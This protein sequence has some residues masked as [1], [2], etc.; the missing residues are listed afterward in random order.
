VTWYFHTVFRKEL[1]LSYLA[2]LTEHFRQVGQDIIANDRW[3]LFTSMVSSLHNSILVPIDHTQEL[4]DYE[5]EWV[6]F[7]VTQRLDQEHGTRRRVESLMRSAGEVALIEEY[8]E[9]LKEIAELDAILDAHISPE[10]R[11]EK[12]KLLVELKEFVA[13]SLKFNVLR[14]AI[15]ALGAFAVMERR[16]NYI[17]YLWE[18]RQP[19]DAD[20]TWV[21]TDITPTNLREAVS[22]YFKKGY[23][24]R[25]ILVWKERHGSRVYLQ[26]YFLLLLARFLQPVVESDGRYPELESF[27]LPVFDVGQ[28]ATWS[29]QR[30]NYSQWFRVSKTIPKCCRRSVSHRTRLRKYLIEICRSF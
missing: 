23:F 14:E 7:D 24:G 19:G 15:F 8:Q 10:H 25:N 28:L 2:I 21:G 13:A 29:P 27:S 22:F 9:W 30:T 26:R 12:D 16:P 1:D 5:H 17:K 18:Y 11:D 20:A 4:W 6:P 3:R